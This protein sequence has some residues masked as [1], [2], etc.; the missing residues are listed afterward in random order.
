MIKKKAFLLFYFTILTSNSF[1]NILKINDST[2]SSVIE[3]DQWGVPHIYGERDSDVAFGLAYAHS[4]DDFKSIQDIILA[5]R[6]M[7]A[8]VYGKEAAVNDYYV[9]LMGFWNNV[10]ENYDEK[11]S[12]DVQNLCDGY[13]SGINLFL[14]DNPSLKIKNFPILSGKDLIVGF[15]HR[16][17]LMFG[18]D[19]VIKK[20]SKKE[21]NS[22]GF[23]DKSNI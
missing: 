22:I 5:S 15:S 11:V 14:M 2:Y 6:G 13:A 20:L 16:M 9:N 4:Q 21:S 10:N 8:S 3:R 7:L 18:L 17:P 23:I 19:G 12:F 1:G